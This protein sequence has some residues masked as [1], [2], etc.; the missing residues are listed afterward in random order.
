MARLATAP[1][2]QP[3]PDA[4]QLASLSGVAHPAGVRLNA[5]SIAVLGAIAAEPGLSNQEVGERAGILSQTHAGE[6]VRRLRRLGLIVNVQ[7][8]RRPQRNAWQLTDAG[9]RL[10]REIGCGRRVAPASVEPASRL[11]PRGVSIVRA[12]GGEPGLSNKEIGQRAGI[13]HPAQIGE[14]LRRLRESGLIVNAQPGRNPKANA[15]QL[16][17]AGKELDTAMRDEFPGVL[18]NGRAP[19]GR[20]VAPES[21]DARERRDAPER[22]EQRFRDAEG[23]L[24]A[25]FEDA[26]AQADE[27]V[28]GACEAGCGWLERVRLG[29]LALLELFDEQPELAMLL[30]VR[31]AQAGPAL[32]RRRS[33]VLAW[34]ARLLDGQ[35]A[36]T[37]AHPPLLTARA[38]VSGVAGALEEQLCSPRPGALVELAQSLMSFIVT[39]FLGAA[40]A[41]RELSRPAVAAP[42]LAARRSA[43]EL[44]HGFSG[45]G[46]RHPLA[47]RVLHAIR[48]Q[49]GLSNAQVAE[50][51]GVID[52]G[53]MSRTL[54]RLSRLGLVE[55]SGETAHLPG[56]PNTWQL[57]SS[58][59]QVESALRYEVALGE[60][61][62]AL[63]RPPWGVTEQ[64]VGTNGAVFQTP[65]GIAPAQ[66][67][68]GG[69]H[70][71][72]RG[73]ARSRAYLRLVRLPAF[74]LPVLHC[75]FRVIHRLLQIA[76][77]L[78]TS[79]LNKR[80]RAPYS[81]VPVECNP[82]LSCLKDQAAPR[83][84]MNM[85]PGVHKH[86]RPACEPGT[87]PGVSRLRA[88]PAH[89]AEARG[90]LAPSPRNRC[91]RTGQMLDKSRHRTFLI[92]RRSRGAGRR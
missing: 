70:L 42:A 11:N 44:L 12:I 4:D 32:G 51:T 78:L 55:N 92:A 48:A 87:Q 41:R 9:E 73:M 40:A 75:V 57:T 69:E 15:W 62:R 33:E 6:V 49:P 79:R 34:L 52:E 17:S 8:G 19:G 35:P 66:A 46:M 71:P 10:A 47:P 7:A 2:C 63:R 1:V 45:R 86:R 82:E 59:E 83:C 31:S 50:L 77:A 67:G 23:A 88:S 28:R 74:A 85:R 29:L 22:L 3:Q 61:Q 81:I 72:A 53:Q 64:S 16:T 14:L 21:R 68:A 76:A 80:C 37:R 43:Q 39:P 58:G 5:S 26:L 30:I 54:A 36:A 56:R 89:C 13:S 65:M 18:G 60:E 90:D 27:R 25:A 20:L 38:V 24:P 91:S 84:W